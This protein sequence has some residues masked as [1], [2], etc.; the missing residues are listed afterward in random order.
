MQVT[1]PG[2]QGVHNRGV[3]LKSRPFLPEFFFHSHGGTKEICVRRPGFEARVYPV[4]FRR[5]LV[6]W[7]PPLLRSRTKRKEP[8]NRT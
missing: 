4:P 1:L 7:P 8:G 5:S 6:H 3:S 2:P